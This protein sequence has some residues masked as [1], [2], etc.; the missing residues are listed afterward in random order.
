MCYK[1][2][3]FLNTECD[4][5]LRDGKIKEEEIAQLKIEFDLF[6]E[7]VKVSDLPCDLKAKIVDLKLKHSY[8]PQRDDINMIKRLIFGRISDSY[9]SHKLK[10]KVEALKNEIKG[11][12]TLIKLNY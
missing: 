4:R 6:I 9:S 1:Y 10:K 11:I 3:V 12:P 7:R 8:H 5:Y 2:F